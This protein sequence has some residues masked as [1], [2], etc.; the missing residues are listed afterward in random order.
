[1]DNLGYPHLPSVAITE[2]FLL[3]CLHVPYERYDNFANLCAL[4]YVSGN[5]D[6]MYFTQ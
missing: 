6:S 3:Y 5:R 4:V 1:M 2:L